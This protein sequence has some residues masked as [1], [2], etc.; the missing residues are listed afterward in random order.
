MMSFRAWMPSKMAKS[1][2]PS[3][4]GW[5][6]MSERICRANSYFGTWMVSPRS[7]MA[8]CRFRR[9]TSRKKGDSK[10]MAP[11]RFRGAVSG[12]SVLK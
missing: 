6:M 2:G 9:S 11:S 3:R 1:S 7:S 8:K 5:D 4:R 12:S 10:S